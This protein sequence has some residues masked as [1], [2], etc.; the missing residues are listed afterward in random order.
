MEEIAEKLG[1]TG[2]LTIL[3]IKSY[4]LFIKVKDIFNKGL[5]SLAISVSLFSS[6]YLMHHAC[7]Y[8]INVIYVIFITIVVAWVRAKI[9]CLRNAYTRAK[10]PPS[11]G[12]ARKNPQSELAGYLRSLFVDLC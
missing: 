6:K 8:C 12:N 7:S 3:C 2:I 5:F 1:Q 11:S 9:K 10:K 4:H